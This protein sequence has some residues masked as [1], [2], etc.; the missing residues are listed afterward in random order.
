MHV[1]D[2]NLAEGNNTAD[3]QG[4]RDILEKAGAKPEVIDRVESILHRLQEV[5]TDSDLE[6]RVVQD[7]AK[8]AV[9]EEECKA[10]S[11]SEQEIKDRIAQGFLTQEAQNLARRILL[12]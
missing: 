9:L 6:V 10:K 8:L 12:P 1:H 5:H 7:A 11:F 2:G 4:P 3:Q